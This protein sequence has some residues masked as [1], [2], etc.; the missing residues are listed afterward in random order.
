[1]DNLTHALAGALVAELWLQMAPPRWRPQRR[2]LTYLSSIAANNLPDLDFLATGLTAGKLGYLLH[3]RGHTHTLLGALGMAALQVALIA[4][5]LRFKKSNDLRAELLPL[6]G[7]SC[8]GVL[9]HLLLDFGNNYGVHPF[10]PFDNRWFYA[11]TTFIIEPWWWSVAG[12]C[13]FGLAHKRTG[14]I[15]TLLIWTLGVVVPWLLPL[16]RAAGFF[17]L[18]IGA[19]ALVV[20]RLPLP[21]LR[22]LQLGVANLLLLYCLQ[23]VLRLRVENFVV[24]QASQGEQQLDLV[25]TPLP[26]VPWCWDLVWVGFSNSDYVLRVGR[27]SALPAWMDAQAC[28]IMREQ[29]TVSLTALAPDATVAAQGVVWDAEYRASA[30]QLREAFTGCHGLAY[31]RFARAPF[32]EQSEQILGDLRYDREPAA[33]FSEISLPEANAACPEWVP[34]WE[35]PRVDVLRWIYGTE[36]APAAP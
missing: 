34:P 32:L 14:R 22:R 17:T 21:P 29:T 19:V 26:G 5:W 25:Q 12:A 6:I 3:H 13:L 24:A 30:R 35:P 36:G 4:W 15:A 9:L 16:P 33:D 20:A 28:P 1:M 2:G 18:G 31:L 11:D 27:A 23:G 7:V 10:W 8:T